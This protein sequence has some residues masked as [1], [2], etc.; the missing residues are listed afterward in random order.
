[1]KALD[2]RV[3]ELDER[4]KEVSRREKLLETALK[5][6]EADDV[7]SLNVGGQ[8][9]IAVSR[10]TL[11]LF[12]DSVLAAQFSGRWDDSLPKDKEGNIFIDQDPA[13]FLELLSFLRATNSHTIHAS[14][15][16][17][18]RL[19][20]AMDILL[21]YYHLTFCVFPVVMCVHSGNVDVK[22][23]GL[24]RF[25][26]SASTP[27]VVYLGQKNHNRGI[28]GFSIVVGKYN[29]LKIGWYAYEIPAGDSNCF[30]ENN[31]SMFLDLVGS[32]VW[33]GS[34]RKVCEPPLEAHE[35]SVVRF[36]QT[37][38]GWSWSVDGGS[39]KMESTNR[40][41]NNPQTLLI[42]MKGDCQISEILYVKVA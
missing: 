40:W 16:P 38:N 6:A 10:R 22:E 15:P 35:G 20:R 27:S 26:V 9:N 11:T 39:A 28:A 14:D 3:K 25:S 29:E 18:P 2:D 4:E 23:E 42:A 8:T 33:D 37:K 1:M 5:G 31:Y 12:E 32:F 7:L 19:S 21:E 17:L 34:S 41:A 36:E 30:G 24:C 13:L